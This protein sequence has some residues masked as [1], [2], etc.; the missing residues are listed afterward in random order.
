MGA[1]RK[2]LILSSITA[3]LAAML[4]ISATLAWFGRDDILKTDDPD[5]GIS[6][7]LLTSY[8]HTDENYVGDG[9][10]EKP[11]VITRPKHWENLIWLHNNVPGFY[12]A[13]GSQQ[14]K[15]YYFRIGHSL[16]EG[17]DTQYVYDYDDDGHLRYNADGSPKVSQVLNLNCYDEENALIP[18]GSPQYPFIGE[19]NGQNLTVSGFEV[20][21]LDIYNNDRP[22]EDIG[23]FGYVG[24]TG[25]CH[26]V[27]FGDFTI[28]TDKA[29]MNEEGEY[30]EHTSHSTTTIFGDHTNYPCIGYLAGHILY[31]K[32]FNNVYINNCDI[33]GTGTQASAKMDNYG[34]YGFVEIP[35]DGSTMGSGHN[36][37]F[38][39]DSSAVYQYMVENYNDIRYN[40]LRPRNTE[41]DYG[42]NNPIPPQEFDGSNLPI[43]GVTKGISYVSSGQNTYNLVGDDPD[44]Y[45]AGEYTGLNYSLSTIGWQPTK[46]DSAVLE[47]ELYT[48]DA[49]GNYSLINSKPEDTITN[50]TITYDQAKASFDNKKYFRWKS[51]ASPSYWEYFGVHNEKDTTTKKKVTFDV[52]TDGEVS[53][54]SSASGF[55]KDVS[56]HDLVGYLFVDNVAYQIPNSSISAE[57][58]RNG[59][60]TRYTYAIEMTSHFQV[61]LDLELGVHHYGAFIG[62][63][64]IDYNNNLS[65][66]FPC[67][68]IYNAGSISKSDNTITVNQKDLS[69]DQDYAATKTESVVISSSYNGSNGRMNTVVGDGNTFGDEDRLPR[70]YDE[71]YEPATPI[72]GLDNEGNYTKIVSNNINFEPVEYQVEV[73]Q[74]A[75]DADGNVIKDEDG[76]II[77][78][79]VLETRHKWKAIYN[80]NRIID[81]DKPVQYLAG[82][83]KEDYADGEEYID[84]SNNLLKKSGYSYKNLDVVGGGIRFSGN[85]RNDGTYEGWI[86]FDGENN[87]RG[88]VPALQNGDLN[89][90]FYSTKYGPNSVVLYL[91]NIG[92]SNAE[93]WMGDIVFDYDLTLDATWSRFFDNSFRTMVFKKGVQSYVD[94]ENTCLPGHEPN[95]SDPDWISTTGDNGAFSRKVTM[96]LRR[97]AV[98]KAAYCAL[99]KN[100]NILCGYDANGNQ[101]LASGTVNERNIAT[102]VLLVGVLTTRIYIPL[103]GY[104]DFNTRVSKID[105]SYVAPNG[106]GG[107][108]GPVEY[109]NTGETVDNTIFNFFFLIP[110]GDKF[111]IHVTYAGDDKKYYIVRL[112]YYTTVANRT[113]QV[114]CY[115]Y[116]IVDY[117]VYFNPVD[118]SNPTDTE[119]ICQTGNHTIN[120][121]STDPNTW[122]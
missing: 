113:L 102:Y 33:E 12:N 63:N 62:F 13:N 100:G 120:V 95:S 55:L 94:F 11:F 109:R 44:D 70:R 10:E 58:E 99:D 119:E 86:T 85:R 52:Y 3:G 111:K 31:A 75:K 105:F 51:E 87:T 32:S 81:P 1:Y 35:E 98:K 60:S 91:H 48:K 25:Y 117:K 47:Y 96:N 106:F 41:Y 64:N 19:L 83:D 14:D 97:G 74:E 115:L 65:N 59:L 37:K 103:Y 56:P 93:D 5:K 121:G 23:I 43:N 24:P 72:Y 9:S 30:A 73:R 114:S 61:T 66:T 45:G 107:S 21:S 38:T 29:K 78:I 68:G 104:V 27:Y 16:V 84:D 15:G 53:W 110:E 112:Y 26:D 39:L 28:N 80:P 6:G 20:S 40:P 54:R 22:L 18:L 82:K 79:N 71:D 42:P 90:K 46:T 101:T 57:V 34:Y 2:K 88:L 116:D 77:Y 122:K 4:T 49:R 50:S 108:F 89:K 36:Y 8:F 76:N 67:V 69:I 118:E 92:G 7:A 17:S